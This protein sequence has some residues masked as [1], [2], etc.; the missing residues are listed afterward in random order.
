MAA[1]YEFSEVQ[2]N[3]ILDMQLRQLTRLSRIDLA[4]RARRD[5]RQHHR[6][7]GDPRQP[8]AS[9]HRD[10][11]TRSPTIKD[12]FATPRVCEL[13]YD[14]G[15]MSIEDLVDDKEL[16]IVMTQAQYVKA[17]SADSFKTQGRGGRG[18]SGGKMKVDDIVRHVIFTTAHAHLLFFSNRGK[19]YRL[20]ALEIPER[21]RTAKGMPIVNLLPLQADETDPGDHRH[22]RLRRRALLVL[23]HQEGHG[24]EDRVRRLRLESPR[25][26]DRHQPARRRR[27]RPCD[28]DERQRR[29]LHGE[30]QR[31]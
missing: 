25:R 30:P 9:Q 2:A 24:Q 7:P 28:R 11:A 14:D 1:P 12:A 23:R 18:V 29:H 26:P 4:D 27:T 17:V 22:P 13:T 5:P 10:Q 6:S 15:E 8:R 20:R 19:V 31:A 21:E 3:D 16:V